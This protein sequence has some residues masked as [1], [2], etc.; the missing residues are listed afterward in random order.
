VDDHGRSGG[1][2]RVFGTAFDA[3]ENDM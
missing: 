1:V 3:P 2:P